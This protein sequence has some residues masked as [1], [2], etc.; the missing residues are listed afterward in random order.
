MAKNNLEKSEYNKWISDIKLKVHNARTQTA[1]SVN[2]SLLE[3]YW[4]IGKGIYTKQKEAKWGSKIIDQIA[5]DLKHEF[6]DIKGLSIRNIYAMRQWY[7]FYSQKFSIVPQVVAQIPWGHNRLIINKIK[8]IDEAL[9]YIQ[10][11]MAG[12]ETF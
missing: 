11:T 9:F 1:L 2:T 4:E 8:D 3:L 7:L 10:E 6:P 12:R 5:I